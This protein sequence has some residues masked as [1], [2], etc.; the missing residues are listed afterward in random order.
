[1]GQSGGLRSPVGARAVDGL[2]KRGGKQGEWG[3]GDGRWQMESFDPG[4]GQEWKKGRGREEENF[5]RST[6][7]IERV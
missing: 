4:S 6:S 1:M 3:M 2:G 7:N 5:E